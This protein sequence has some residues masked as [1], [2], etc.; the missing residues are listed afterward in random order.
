MSSSSTIRR[1]CHYI[2]Y[3]KKILTSKEIHRLRAQGLKWY[4]IYD[5]AKL[6]L[7]DQFNN[8]DRPEFQSNGT[9]ITSNP[10][11]I[12]LYNQISAEEMILDNYNTA[13]IVIHSGGVWINTPINQNVCSKILS[14]SVNHYQS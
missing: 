3:A 13:Q 6:R 4:E 8:L 14:Q 9:K 5:I 7:T 2:R 12:E 1:Y 11:V 10:Y